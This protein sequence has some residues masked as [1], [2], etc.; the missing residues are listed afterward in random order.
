MDC[1]GKPLAGVAVDPSVRCLALH[2]SFSGPI[3]P[4][5]MVIRSWSSFIARQPRANA[6]PLL[7]K[8]VRAISQ[9]KS[10]LIS[11]EETYRLIAESWVP[12]HTSRLWG[13]F[14][15]LPASVS[16]S[17]IATLQMEKVHLRSAIQHGPP[18]P[19]KAHESALSLLPFPGHHVPY[20][21]RRLMAWIPG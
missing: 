10:H 15:A 20:R 1:V 19:H 16:L 14:P 6:S 21:F 12:H 3:V 5:G 13:R 7:P 11:I 17:N 4:L 2:T 8:A 18:T 9:A